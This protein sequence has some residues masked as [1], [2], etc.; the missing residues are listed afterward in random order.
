M[1]NGLGQFKKIKFNLIL[2][3]LILCFSVV[4]SF[5]N[6]L[7]FLNWKFYDALVKIHRKEPVK[8]KDIVI[9]NIDQSSIDTVSKNLKHY[10]P[11]PRDFYAQI[12][13]FLA[14]CGAK[15]IIFDI[16]FSEPD[17]DRIQANGAD[18]D[19]SFGEA[20]KESGI[21]YLTAVLRDSVSQNS[22]DGNIF[23]EKTP[24]FLKLKKK[25]YSVAGFPIPVLSQGAKGICFANSE[26]ESDNI[27]R[28]YSLV[29][30]YRDGFVS[31]TAYE[32][33]RNVLPKETLEKN[34]N[35][36]FGKNTKVDNEGKILIN[37]YG[38]G[39]PD[40]VFINYSFHAALISSTQL[41]T[42]EK[43]LISPDCFKDKIVF[44]GSSA[45]GLLDL[46]TTPFTSL[47]EY[48]G[49]EVHAT[50][51]ANILNNDMMYN[52]PRWILLISM[53]LVSILLFIFN[54]V[55]KNLKTFIVLFFG[56]LVFEVLLSYILITGNLW[57]PGADL[58]VNTTLVFTGLVISGYFSETKDKRLLRKQFER[59]VNDNVLEEILANPLSVDV[60]GRAVNATIL[61][62][63]IADFTTIS[64]SMSSREVV[65]RLN[66]YLSETSEALI[67]H[68]AFINKYIGDAI[69]A[70][71][72]AFEEGN[73]RK[74]A[75]LG[76][77]RA[78][79]IIN[80][81][82]S[83]AKEKGEMPLHTRFGITTGEVTLGNI[84]SERK[85]EYTVIGD[86]VN[87]AF[88]LEGLNKFYGTT[89][90]VSE[91]TREGNENEF[92]FRWVDTLR[93]KGKISPVKVY[94]LLGLKGEVN[95]KVIINRDKYEDALHLY[96]KRN[97][98]E[99]MNTFSILAQEGDK[100]SEILSGRCENFIKNPPVDE[101]DGVW[102][103][104]RK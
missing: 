17:T 98:T 38:R 70:V 67:E 66:N 22:L 19:N 97:F 87:S 9:I 50:A 46:K 78:L 103:M 40:G 21:T 6:S 96:M 64:E 3:F 104:M 74:N 71:F 73:H 77:L 4:L 1:K 80:K 53:F 44:I 10:W 37:W 69:L 15:A 90:L 47:K 26:P 51:L 23:L 76:A 83:E 100:A 75:C 13:T 52:L 27:I 8:Q 88:R 30:K 86:A 58:I 57:M 39:G 79:S 56:L 41:E 99:A 43:P 20:V 59:Y 28:R 61:A 55:Y 31:S 60:K 33:A 5:N 95:E 89:M 24:Y 29:F 42:G 7:D 2:T 32:V 85:T 25:I 12:T 49:V 92:E 18:C 93:Y 45:E 84:G 16:I 35:S 63:D 82:I 48:P 11:W 101:W 14:S 34:I 68:G 102:V 36:Y 94:E 91:Y 65:S 62:T 72:G 81:K 54:N